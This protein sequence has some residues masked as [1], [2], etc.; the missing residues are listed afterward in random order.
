MYI[1]IPVISIRKS[2]SG[3]ST[4]ELPGNIGFGG[5]GDEHYAE[6]YP[7]YDVCMSVCIYVYNCHVIIT[8][9]SFECHIIMYISQSSH[10][11]HMIIL[12]L[13]CD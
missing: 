1:N 12:L 10:D 6:C 7:G 9:V 4:K 8:Q 11:Y 3:K 2:D 13:S 5:F